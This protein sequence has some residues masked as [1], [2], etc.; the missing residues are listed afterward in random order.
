[1][2]HENLIWNQTVEIKVSEN[3]KRKK[4]S[5]VSSLREAQEYFPFSPNVT[6]GML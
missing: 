6:N 2:R 1:M 3:F 4:M 5:F